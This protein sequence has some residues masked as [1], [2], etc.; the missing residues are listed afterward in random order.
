M[1][2]GIW[3]ELNRFAV[4][5]IAK[6][7]AARRSCAGIGWFVG[8]TYELLGVRHS[9]T[10]V[11]VA[12]IWYP[13]KAPARP[14]VTRS[15]TGRDQLGRIGYNGSMVADFSHDIGRRHMLTRREQVQ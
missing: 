1:R 2:G 12:A 6:L 13:D 11:G 3:Q 10:Y 9:L 14:S 7:Q 4:E 5:P 8:R 15:L